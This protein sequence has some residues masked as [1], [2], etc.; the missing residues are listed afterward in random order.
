MVAIRRMLTGN[1]K[2]TSYDMLRST[3]MKWAV[4]RK[5]ERDRKDDPMDIDQA[6][7]EGYRWSLRPRGRPILD[8]CSG[9]T[10]V[11]MG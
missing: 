4:D 1:S 7:A 11:D 2:I 5:L 9:S 8:W 6:E 3:I 10:M